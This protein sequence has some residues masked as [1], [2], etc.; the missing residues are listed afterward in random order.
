VTPYGY[1]NVTQSRHNGIEQTL[2]IE[3]GL[4][5]APTTEKA[6]H[7]N[8]AM[9]SPIDISTLS[10]DR[11][12]QVSNGLS[13]T[14]ISLLISAIFLLVNHVR[15]LPR[16]RQSIVILAMV[17]LIAAY[18]YWRIFDSFEAA[19]SSDAVFNECYRYME[20]I[21]AV[22]LLLTALVK[23][24]G[25]PRITRLKLIR[26]LVP[27]SVAMIALG[28]LGEI[29]TGTGNKLLFW[30]LSAIPFI[31][32]LY[33]LYIQVTRSLDQ[34]VPAVVSLVARLRVLVTITWLIYPIAYLLPL[35]DLD[36][37]VGFMARE[38]GYSVADI[39]AKCAFS[40]MIYRLARL[41]SAHDD[42]AFAERE[43]L[44]D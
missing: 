24:L 41:N 2:S 30:L 29:S 8:Y 4:A 15:V 26:R 37:Q 19:H 9:N 38:F 27:S 40:L 23:A 44:N 32:I 16:Y 6:C 43:G 12:T 13:I 21:L 35:M 7:G 39:L 34:Q 18:H 25:L 22:P 10:I 5:R 1:L 36:D 17:N 33:V 3:L 31:Y 28:Y 11:F 14:F 42:P 20:W